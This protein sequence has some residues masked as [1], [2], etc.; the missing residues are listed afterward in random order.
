MQNIFFFH[1]SL[2]IKRCLTFITLVTAFVALNGCVSTLDENPYTYTPSASPYQDVENAQQRAVEQSKLLLV[3]LGAQW[4]H[5]STGLAERFASKEM[6]LIL[7]AHY[8]TIFVDVGTLEDR[9]NITQRFDYPIYYATPT[10]MVVEPKTGALLN[11]TSMDIWGRA[12]SIPL[13]EYIQYFSRFP[14]MTTAQKAPFINWQATDEEKAYNKEQAL[15][16]QSAYD[17]LG[18]MLALDLQGNTPQGLNELWK[19][20]KGFRTELQKTLIKRAELSLD[21]ENG[22]GVNTAPALRHY[23]PFSWEQN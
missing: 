16:L 4:C 23:N 3:V 1:H 5:D 9:R 17:K 2:F 20:T 6:D 12:D 13:S 11:R 7:R 21:S 22:N 8:E 19:E 15:R 18:P 14:A 10:V